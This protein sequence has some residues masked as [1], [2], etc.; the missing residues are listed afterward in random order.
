MMYQ[1]GESEKYGFRIGMFQPDGGQL[2]TEDVIAKLKKVNQG[3][4]EFA[5]RY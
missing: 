4:S 1:A 3:Y 5:S 2:V